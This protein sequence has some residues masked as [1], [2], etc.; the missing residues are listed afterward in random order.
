MLASRRA[1]FLAGAGAAA[2]AALVML[3]LRLALDS[4]SLA[5]LVADRLT[6]L[7]PLPLFQAMLALLG[8]AAKRLFFGGVLLGM[9]L[10]G[11]LL[12]A[13]AARRRLGMRD[14]LKGLGVLWLATAWLGLAS[15]GV[16]A[17]GT[18]TR[19]GPVVTSLALLAVCAAF[20][21]A[22][23]G[24]A[25]LLQPALA[26]D[27]A[28]P[29]RRRLLRLAGLGGVAVVAAGAGLWQLVDNLTR[30]ATSAV[31][32]ALARGAGTLPPE[33][34]PVGQ[35]YTVSKNFFGDPV[36]DAASWRLEVGGTVERPYTLTYD[37]LRALPA[38]DDVRTLLCI[39][40]EVGGDLIGNAQW[41]GVRLRDLLERA[42]PRSGAVKVIFTCAD[43][44]QD[45]IRYDKAMQP[46]TIVVYEMNG[47]PLIPKHGYPARLLVPGIYG[48][49]NVKW[50]RQIEV[51]DKPFLGFWQQRGWSDE[52]GIKTMSRL[53]TVNSITTV[54]TEPLLVGGVAFAGDRG[55]QR[56]EFTVDNGQTWQA[57]Q[58]KAP[59]GPYT[60]VLWMAE[61]TPPAPAQ[62]AL[63]VRATDKAGVLQTG[64]RAEPLPDGASGYHGVSLRAIPS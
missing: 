44:Y 17:F 20:G 61:W 54:S 36:V 42:A 7:V 38:V 31:S 2:L 59:L 16:G 34:T 27:A 3:V 18:L 45:S 29:S 40:N 52:A 14:G 33:I 63:K 12:G 11:G 49:K 21:A 51:T 58:V 5:E 10:L 1:G 23:Y 60:W 56:V 25:R 47:A 46:D 55:I 6:L 37:D 43:D 15:L 62:Y 28:D 26:A 22:F 64:I 41:R 9:V 8:S 39:S 19:Q 53:D 57:A 13:M 32:A 30:G 4:P 24:L 48:M 50:V 35:F